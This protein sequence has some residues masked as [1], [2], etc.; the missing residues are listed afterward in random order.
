MPITEKQRRWLKGEAHH[1]KPVVMIGQA[2]LTDGVLAELELALD[3]HE[4]VKVKVNAGDRGERDA[5]IA[6]MVERTGATLVNRIGNVAV[7]FR[8]NPEKRAPLVLPAI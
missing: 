4:L 2:G 5:M 8:A 6:P 7:L 1:L 3:H